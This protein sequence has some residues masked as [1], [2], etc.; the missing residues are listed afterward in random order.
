MNK[1][2]KESIS[3][4]EQ[5]LK[6]C[7]LIA[8]KNL[9]LNNIFYNEKFIEL[10]VA[11]ILDKSYKGNT[12]GGDIFDKETGKPI[13]IK[14]IN[15]RNKN[16][17]GSFQFHWLSNKKMEKYKQTEYMYF[18]I[19]DGVEIQQIYKIYT[20]KILPLIYKKATGS[21]SIHGHKGFSLNDLI[22]LNPKKVYDYK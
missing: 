7:Q 10:F 22:K 19:R 15:I 13:E 12:Q 16:K 20:N 21:K 1:K 6:Q 8:K 5:L 3:E 18:V 17:T 9:E 11:K 4:I 2:E 14:A